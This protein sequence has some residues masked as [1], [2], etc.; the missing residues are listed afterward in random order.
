MQDGSHHFRGI[1]D[2]DTLRTGLAFLVERTPDG[3]VATV[4]NQGAGHALPTYITPRIRVVLE[5]R[6]RNA[7]SVAIIQR[8]MSWDEDTGWQELF[9]TRLLPGE[10][11][12][13]HLP[14]HAKDHATASVIVEPDADYHERVYPFLIER[15]E[16]AISL[17]A[18]RQLKA[19]HASEK[20]QFAGL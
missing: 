11:R 15:L 7:S 10:S 17:A 8:A 1:H 18:L 20:T 13:V 4:S 9:D 2:P 16:G 3:I 5:N 14:L 12:R 19:A 6:E